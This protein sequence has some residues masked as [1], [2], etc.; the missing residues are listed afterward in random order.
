MVLQDTDT[1]AKAAWSNR[2][3]AM[4]D[5]CTAAVGALAQ[6]GCLKDGLTEDHATDAL[7]S[8]LSVRMWEHLR[9]DCGWTQDRYV[10][11][12]Q[13]MASDLLMQREG[14]VS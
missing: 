12:M 5:G 10:D 8:L 14:Q 13:T 6:D 4:R 1:E 9:I 2:M 7:W 11:L 3:S